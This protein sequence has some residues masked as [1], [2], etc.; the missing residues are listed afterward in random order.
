[1]LLDSRYER[2]A[3]RFVHQWLD[4]Q[5]LDFLK[6]EGRL[7]IALKEAMQLEPV[8]FF[9]ETL[10]RNESVLNFIHAYFTM[11]N[12]RLA[13]HYGLTDVHGNHFRRVALDP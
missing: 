8:L 4:M 1:M 9:Q 11:A 3:A 12:E 6:P 5:L 10:R 13:R 2:F 7:D